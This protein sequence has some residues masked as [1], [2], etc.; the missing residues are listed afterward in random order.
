MLAPDHSAM[1]SSEVCAIIS[2][3]KPGTQPPVYVAGTFSDPPWK[4]HEMAYTTNDDGEHVFTKEFAA[5]PGTRV[6]YKFRIG[7]GDWWVLHDDVP[8]VKDSNGN[9]N[10]ELVVSQPRG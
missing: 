8:T 2:Y 9:E 5:E 7:T 1:E 4:P 6:Q 10:H 3:E